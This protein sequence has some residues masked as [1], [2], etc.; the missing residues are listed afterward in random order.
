[1]AKSGKQTGPIGRPSILDYTRGELEAEFESLGEK[2]F[3]AGQVVRWVFARRA[4]AFDGM[5]DL[6]LE[7]RVRL[8]GSFRVFTSVVEK[9]LVDDAGNRKLLV[10]YPD[11]A[12]VECVLMSEGGRSVACLSTQVGCPIGCVFC[13]S[14]AGGFKRN[15]TA[16]EIVEQLLHARNAL[17]S[18]ESVHGVV[19]MGMG[20]PLLNTEAV[21]RSIGILNA[22]WGGGIGARHITVSTVGVPRGMAA[23][24][25]MGRQVTLAV[26]LHS[27]REDVRRRLIPHAPTGVD[28]LLD[29]AARYRAIAKRRITLE[30]V[31]IAGVNDSVKD[32]RELADK[33]RRLRP[34]VNLIPMNP[35]P[36]S[37]LRAPGRKRTGA[38]RGALESSG[39]TVHVRTSKGVGVSAGC[40]QL[41]GEMRN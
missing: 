40:G 20:E 38:F 5:T 1:M 26:S 21:V 32:A 10:R 19:Y 37:G 14:G 7:C 3:R 33:T 30:Y 31:L 22:R 29:A 27:V 23:L 17:P 25:R 16:G 39:V 18:G 24:A 13:A 4:S 34:H 2:R 6:S 9:T 11:G 41:V 8:A 35:V 15:L 12:A 28:K 36:G